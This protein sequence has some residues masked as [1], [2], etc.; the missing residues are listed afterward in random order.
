MEQRDIPLDSLLLDPNNYRLQEVSGYISVPEERFQLEQVQKTT[1]QRLQKESLK[2]LQKSVL[3][4]GFLPIE[5]IVVTP[6][7]NNDDVY[8]VI[9]GNR[10]VAALISLREQERSGIEIPERVSAVFDAVPC[11]VF[12]DDGEFP[13]FKETLMGVRHVGGIKEWGGYQRAKLIADLRDVHKLDSPEISDRL[14]LP[15]QEVN[16]RYRAF[17]ALQQMEL[18]EDFSE[19][20]DPAMYPLFH[21]AIS[22]PVVRTWLGWNDQTT[23]F[24]NDEAQEQFYQLITPTIDQGT[25]RRT[26]AKLRTYSDVRELKR[27]L[28][29]NEAKSL[30]LDDS[31]TFLDALTIA[32]KDELSKK[33]KSEVSEAATALQKIGALEVK[34]LTQDDVAAIENLRDMATQVLAIHT[35]VTAAMTV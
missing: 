32:R 33:W 1:L 4:N 35:T 9:E 16:R 15:L 27:I 8:L 17:K 14:G 26:D 23:A 5:R 28:P 3:A 24:D 18:N 29:N 12:E 22:L 6:Y 20:A 25:G 34:N 11:I 19:H 7:L 10:R 21:E 31:R 2:E 30:L 13:F